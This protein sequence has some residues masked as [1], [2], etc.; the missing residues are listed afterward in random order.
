VIGGGGGGGGE[1]NTLMSG[2]F[3]VALLEK[4]TGRSFAPPKAGSEA[5]K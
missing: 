5:P 4:L 2:L 3:G 1:G